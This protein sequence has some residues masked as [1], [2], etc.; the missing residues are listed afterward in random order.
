M[1]NVP[2]SPAMAE[3]IDDL[4]EALDR[5]SIGLNRAQRHF[6]YFTNADQ[7]DVLAALFYKKDRLIELHADMK[8]SVFLSGLE[9]AISTERRLSPI[10]VG[11]VKPEEPSHRKFDPTALPGAK[12]YARRWNA[13]GGRC[14]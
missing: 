6:L 13:P 4:K 3:K 2:Y 5:L 7:K 8:N 11:S 9:D 10:D 1:T 12:R 14:K